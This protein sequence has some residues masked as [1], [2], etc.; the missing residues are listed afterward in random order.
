MPATTLPTDE[1]IRAAFRTPG[2]VIEQIP[3]TAAS[4]AASSPASPRNCAAANAGSKI[5]STRS[6]SSARHAAVVARLLILD[7]HAVA[8]E[9][10]QGSPELGEI[11]RIRRL[12]ISSLLCVDW[13]WYS[14]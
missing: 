9:E 5:A 12:I 14:K 13:S 6:A 11:Q 7:Q 1:Q 8:V 2:R 4:K 3:G 10:V